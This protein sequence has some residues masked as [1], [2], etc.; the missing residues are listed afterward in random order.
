MIDRLVRGALAAKEEMGFYTATL[1]RASMTL[2]QGDSQTHAPNSNRAQNISARTDSIYEAHT[3]LALA[4]CCLGSATRAR[5]GASATRLDLAA[6]L[7]TST[8]C[9]RETAR[10]AE[11]SPPE[12][13]E[14]LPADMRECL[15]A[16]PPG[17]ARNASPP[18]AS[19][20]CA[21]SSPT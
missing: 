12:V 18:P 14:L 17:E 10:R 4:A 16:Q 8:G 15:A 3:S 11:L 7:I 1:T 20:V 5:C 19:T 13:A 2:A 9:T 21:T 6:R